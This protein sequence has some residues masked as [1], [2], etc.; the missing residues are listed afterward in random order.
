MPSQAASAATG[1]RR[2]ALARDSLRDDMASGTAAASGGA[3]P[4]PPA[5]RQPGR[6]PAKRRAL[7]GGINPV[8]STARL[9]H[10]Q[11][12]QCGECR[13]PRRADVRRAARIVSSG[14]RLRVA[15][16]GDYWHLASRDRD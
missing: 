10:G 12:P 5:T 14:R 15:P 7:G 16:C 4:A 11:W 9:H 6:S 1:S 3:A 13:D 2:P 8:A